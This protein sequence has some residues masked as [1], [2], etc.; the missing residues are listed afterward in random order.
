[1]RNLHSI[2]YHENAA[3]QLE[4]SNNNTGNNPSHPAMR[5]I[6]PPAPELQEAVQKLMQGGVSSHCKY[7]NKQH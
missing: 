5:E 7:S 4:L 3:T 6:V 1:M 2:Q